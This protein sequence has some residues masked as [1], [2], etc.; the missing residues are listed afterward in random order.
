M[1]KQ[2]ENEFTRDTS[3]YISYL[4]KNESIFVLGL[5][6]SIP[7][8]HCPDFFQGCS[9]GCTLQESAMMS[10]KDFMCKN[11]QG[12][13]EFLCGKLRNIIALSRAEEQEISNNFEKSFRKRVSMLTQKNEDGT[14]FVLIKDKEE[15][16]SIIKNIEHQMIEKFQVELNRINKQNVSIIEQMQDKLSYQDGLIKEMNTTINNLK[17]NK[18]EI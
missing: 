2:L 17:K 15:L 11:F 13:E 4:D 9:G 3:F 14:K 10:D 12:T 8:S 1:V 7:C 6:K 18:I 5:L 16:N